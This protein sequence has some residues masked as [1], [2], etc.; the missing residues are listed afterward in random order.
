MLKKR[1]I[2][3]LY[4]S[5]RNHIQ[6]VKFGR[7]HRVL[8]DIKSSVEVMEERNVDEVILIDVD[9]TAQ[10][11][12]PNFKLL[13]ELSGA[14]YCPVTYGG[15]IVD[16][17]DAKECL[18]HGADKVCIK[19]LSYNDPMRAIKIV[20]KLGAQS[21]VVSMDYSNEHSKYI[22]MRS[23]IDIVNFVKPGEILATCVDCNGTLGGYDIEGLRRLSDLLPMPIIA[24]GGCGSPAHMQAALEA[25]AHAV[26][27]SSMWSFT[28]HTPRSCVRYLSKHGV[29][30]RL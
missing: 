26:A 19:T 2:P 22:P 10:G 15:G 8:G 5:G 27:A 4:Y 23:W 14:L 17:E 30:V 1:I 12:P 11:R 13:A 9:A 3:V 18:L 25:G 6:S 20:D 7:P 29:E 24:S 16:V 21:V 28:D